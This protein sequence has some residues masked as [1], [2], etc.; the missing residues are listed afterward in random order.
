MC[1]SAK[2][3][4][5]IV[6]M[7]KVKECTTLLIRL[8]S[9][10]AAENINSPFP[11]IFTKSDL[12]PKKCDVNPLSNLYYDNIVSHFLTWQKTNKSFGS[13]DIP[14]ILLKAWADLISFPLC[15][16]L[17]CP[18]GAGFTHSKENFLLSQLSQRL[19]N[20]T[21][22]ISLIIHVGVIWSFSVFASFGIFYRLC[23]NYYS[24][25]CRQ[26]P[27]RCL[28]KCCTH[29]NVRHDSSFWLRTS[30]PPS[31]IYRSV[32]FSILLKLCSLV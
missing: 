12:Y 7:C 27:I 3:L 17:T 19:V 14:L 13:G 29:C 6:K 10:K 25:G 15:S 30:S 16:F 23:F 8:C 21:R 1:A 18:L 22:P 11:E 24:R 5:S 9:L 28:C 32:G 31:E 4:W 20:L 2:G 26:I